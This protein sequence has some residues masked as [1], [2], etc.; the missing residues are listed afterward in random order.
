M[1]SLTAPI[2]LPVTE[3]QKAFFNKDIPQLPVTFSWI[4]RTDTAPDM[5]VIEEKLNELFHAEEALFVRFVYQPNMV[6]PLQKMA[7][8]DGKHFCFLLKNQE[9]DSDSFFRQCAEHMQHLGEY[10]VFAASK[11]PDAGCYNAYLQ[12]PFGVVDFYSI[13]KL[14]TAIQMIFSGKPVSA[15]LISYPQ[16][17]SWQIETLKNTPVDIESWFLQQ[18]SFHTGITPF[19]FEVN[20][21]E[22]S[23]KNACL[24]KVDASLHTVADHLGVNVKDC[25]YAIFSILLSH[26]TNRDLVIP[27]VLLNGRIYDELNDT[28]GLIDQVIPLPVMHETDFKTLVNNISQLQAERQSVAEYFSN[29]FLQ[30]VTGNVQPYTVQYIKIPEGVVHFSDWQVIQ[31]G[32]ALQ[33]DVLDTGTELTTR[34]SYN[35]SRFS[36]NAIEQLDLVLQRLFDE[37]TTDINLLTNEFYPEKQEVPSDPDFSCLFKTACKKYDKEIAL[38]DG[39]ITYTYEALEQVTTK[40]AALL[41][42]EKGVR[43]GDLIAISEPRSANVIIAILA[44]LKAGAAFLPVDRSQPVSRIQSILEDADPVLILSEEDHLF[45]DITCSLSA[46]LNATDN[47]PAVAFPLINADDLAYVIYTSGTTGK[48]KGCMVSRS[49]LS[50]YL[51][52]CLKTY[53]KDKTCGN[54]PWFT[55][56]S[57]DLTITGIFLPLITGKKIVVFGEEKEIDVI[58]KDCFSGKEGIDCIKLTPSH[59]NLLNNVDL[60][61]TSIQ[62]VITGGEQLLPA[63]AALL[64]KLNKDILL[65]NE[66]GP[67]EATVG[68][69]VKNIKPDDQLITIGRPIDGINAFILSNTLKPL[70][71]G[72]AGELFLTGNGITKGYLHNK[73]LTDEKFITI[74]AYNDQVF[75]RTGDLARLLPDGEFA[76]LGRID[77]QVKIR[78]YRI[79]T[80]EIIHHLNNIKG[81]IN[82]H[83]LVEQHADSPELAAFFE[84][85][86]EVA[87]ITSVLEKVLPVYMLPQYYYRVQE[88]PL[89]ANGKVDAKKLLS[90]DLTIKGED[91]VYEAPANVMEEKIADIWKELLQLEQ[92][93][94]HD[95]FFTSGGQSI[96]ASALVARLNKHFQAGFTLKDIFEYPLLSQQ[97]IRASKTDNAVLIAPVLL[98]AQD[99]YD[100]SGQQLRIWTEHHATRLSTA[101]NMPVAYQVQGDFSLQRFVAAFEKLIGRFESLRTTFVCDSKGV[102]KQ[103]IHTDTTFFYQYEEAAVDIE[104]TCKQHAQIHIP[105]DVLPLYRVALYKTAADKWQLVMNLHHI[106]ADG[107][108]EE[109]LLELLLKEYGQLSDENATLEF[110]YKE[111]AAWQNQQVNTDSRNYWLDKFKSPLPAAALAIPAPP[112]SAQKNM[113]ASYSITLGEVL[114]DKLHA[115]ATEK[116]ITLFPLLLSL[117]DLLL[118]RY[119]GDRDRVIAVPADNRLHEVFIQQVGF[120]LN[121]LLLRNELDPGISFSQLTDNWNLHLTEGQ[122][123]KQYPYELLAKELVMLHGMPGTELFHILVNFQEREQG[124]LITTGDISLEKLHYDYQTHAKAGLVFNFSEHKGNLELTVDFNQDLY[125]AHFIRQMLRHCLQLASALMAQPHNPVGKVPAL[126]NDEVAQLLNCGKGSLV[127][128]PVDQTIIS[129]FCDTATQHGD[130]HAIVHQGK[131]VTYQRL[132]EQVAAMSTVLKEYGIV[133]GQI[134]PVLAVRN[135]LTITAMLAVMHCGAVYLPIDAKSPE[136]RILSVIRQCEAVLVLNTSAQQF[137]LA[138]TDIRIPAMDADISGPA[139]ITGPAP[140]YMIFT[141]GSTGKPK[142]LT[143]SHTG[144]LNTIA[145]QI[146]GFGVEETDHCLWFSSPAFDASLSEIFLALLSGATVYTAD[147]D[148]INNQYVFINWMTENNIS[149][150]TIPPAY[151]C[152]LS[153]DLPQS[154]RVLISAGEA[155]PERMG[156]ALANRHMLFNAYGPSENAICT[157]FTRIYRGDSMMPIGMPVA[158]VNVKVLDGDD[159]PV[160]AGVAGELHIAGIGLTGGYYRNEEE[161][162]QRFYIKD[163]ECWYRTGDFVRWLHDGRLVFIGRKDEQVKINGNRVELEDIRHCITAHHLVKD[164]LIV[165]EKERSV[166]VAYIVPEDPA[167]DVEMMTLHARAALPAYMVPAFFIIVP[168]IPLTSNGKKDSSRLPSPFESLQQPTSFT[169]SAGEKLIADIYSLLL[170]IQANRLTNFFAAGGDSLRAIQLISAIYKQCER[171]VTL[172]DLY[173]YPEVRALALQLDIT[174]ED[175]IKETQDNEWINASPMQ[176][177]IWADMEITGAQQYLMTGGFELNGPLDEALFRQALDRVLD[178]QGMLRARFRISGEGLQF[179]LCAPDISQISCSVE[180]EELSSVMMD[181]EKDPLCRF[182]LKKCEDGSHIFSFVLHHLV[183]DAWSIK[184][185]ITAVMEYYATGNT[186]VKKNITPYS[187]YTNSLH[188]LKPFNANRSALAKVCL[189]KERIENTDI[190][191]GY[192]KQAFHKYSGENI[193]ALAG[194]YKVSPLAL[195][196][197]LQ[198]L[199]FMEEQPVLTIFAPLHGRFE[200]RWHNTVGLFMNVVPFSVYKHLYTDVSDLLE[201]VQTQYTFFLND[202]AQYMAQWV[203]SASEENG[204]RGILEIH[205]DDFEAHYSEETMALPGIM[206]RPVEDNLM[207]RKFS[208]ELHIKSG[209]AGFSA[210]CLYDQR[211]YSKKFVEKG[212]GRF[213]QILS[214]LT[215]QPSQ[216]IM[217][218]ENK[219]HNSEKDKME[220]I[221]LNSLRAFLK[222]N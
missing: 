53:T 162:Q 26:F 21:D 66:Y 182:H 78:G 195:I 2:T 38:H 213:E 202:T 147:P 84:G 29:E 218:L 214:A 40:L 118:Y 150:A 148:V 91:K 24:H 210:E 17:V 33:L 115:F 156:L 212:I 163:N 10:C 12:I 175:E 205:I 51:H 20:S 152:A 221:Q 13:G 104:Q 60:T 105:L 81:V 14:C 157:T 99:D 8:L 131:A 54:F 187:V 204:D 167:C 165:Y 59:I 80:D 166:L 188:Q 196:T 9:R 102:P 207:S 103:V 186:T 125:T 37:V 209:K 174:R 88:I 173:K 79:E 47:T 57:F 189:I 172:G 101:Y 170:G 126:S 206:I 144:L 141:S 177:K 211:S 95:H 142:G 176:Q 98:P 3:R 19:L 201:H 127:N 56:L 23:Y 198:A 183:A 179:R 68:C 76:F 185:I 30:N 121:T 16:Y 132:A 139:D 58:L 48:P 70:L 74:P 219:L 113:A 7:P 61:D 45:P 28:L 85:E 109:I 136:E 72:L 42:K 15:P 194:I 153:A 178:E 199:A 220:S 180:H 217:A 107:L 64:F 94:R 82:A 11:H 149:V 143:I 65:F 151:L 4:I 129:R 110:Q 123:H 27:G 49:N 71:P 69:I 39:S 77:Q 18:L 168:V 134:V 128:I 190:G 97:A 100:L 119:G 31:P 197:G 22:Y 89:T 171:S 137:E 87:E 161:T 50:H 63:Q 169:M 93:G 46:L 34:W 191:P 90:H 159:M 117:V 112:V 192:F 25:C 44:V 138:D 32:V 140:A 200:T 193:A 6:Y 222:K 135:E 155:L 146:E 43:P 145:A 208:M 216:T 184:V 215:D 133:P 122:Q 73:T 114:S 83:V 36:I 55:P 124:D 35:S 5:L 62:V 111:Y 116:K 154:L 52:W 92:V 41:I 120:F 158:N 75:Y 130:H 86:A 96:K 181:P 108:S 160:P 106:I 203:P 67:T 1:T 164:A